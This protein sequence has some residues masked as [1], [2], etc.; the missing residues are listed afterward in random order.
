MEKEREGEINGGRS[1]GEKGRT[2][3]YQ[4]DQLMPAVCWR[5]KS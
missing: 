5:T 1:R 4:I 3:R 2:G